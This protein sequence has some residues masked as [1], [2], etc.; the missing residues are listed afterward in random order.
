MI[1]PI[2]EN[3]APVLFNPTIELNFTQFQN[4]ATRSQPAFG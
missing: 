1:G 4:L 2:I 3:T